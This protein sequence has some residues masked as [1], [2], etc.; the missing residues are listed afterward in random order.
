MKYETQVE[1]LQTLLKLREDDR[2]QEMLGRV[3]KIPVRVYTEPDVLKNELDT[4]FRDYPLVAGHASQVREPGSYLLSSWNRIPYVVVR[5]KEG[6]LRAFLNT[7]RHRGA[8]LVSGCEKELRAFVCPFH[9]WTYN[10]D[11]SLKAITKDYNF[12]DINCDHYNLKELPVKE[13]MGLIW[14]HPTPG[15]T[16]DLS[17]FLGTEINSDI[18]HFE[19]DKLK[20]HRKEVLVKNAN[21]KLLLKTY[22]ERYHV[23][24]MHRKTIADLFV[25]GV[26]AHFEHGPH[27]RMAAARTNLPEVAQV[28]PKSWRLLNYAAVLY[29][30]FPNTLLI[31]LPGG[32]V[33]INSFYP[34]GPDKTI[35]TH[36]MLYMEENYPGEEGQKILA[37]RFDNVHSNLFDK[38]DFGIAEDIQKGLRHGAN[39]FHTMGLE[40]GLVAL[41]QENIDQRLTGSR[42]PVDQS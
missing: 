14:V 6:V 17:S 12:P 25:K 30:L 28:D 8:R 22:L 20:M 35:W 9:G 40:E 24:V 39:E 38:E 21:W 16:I 36:E 26:I 4:V 32:V 37:A 3:V 41:F 29:I 10:L 19:F 15:A 27:I 13:S 42:V 33:S 18:E 5:D 1:T 7:C 34:E 31:L 11:G 23:P 2:D